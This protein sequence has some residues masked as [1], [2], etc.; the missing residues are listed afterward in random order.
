VVKLEVPSLSQRPDDIIPMAKQFL[1]EFSQKFNKTFRGLSPETETALKEYDWPGNV[2]ELKNLIERGVLLSDGPVLM[3]ED[4]DLKGINGR[5][6]A[7]QPDNGHHLPSVCP[8]G[9]DFSAIIADIEKSYFEEALKL[10]NGNESKAALLL[11]LTR[12]KF[13]YRRQ[14]L[15]G[16]R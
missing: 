8:A 13:R 11:N 2:R 5:E 4:L 1:V 16:V 14:K 7:K 15:N 10:A 9:I 12:D 3:L 6:S